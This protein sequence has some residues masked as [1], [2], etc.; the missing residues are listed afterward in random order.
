VQWINQD[1][2]VQSFIHDREGRKMPLEYSTSMPF[3]GNAKRA[4]AVAQS[5]LLASNFVV[6]SAS[7]FE[8]LVKCRGTTS[9]RENPLKGMTEGR[10]TVRNS[11]I[12]VSAVLGGAQWLRNFLRIMPLAMAAFFIS[13]FGILAIFLP[14]MRRWWIFPIP[15]A[16]L[17]PWVVLAP[18]LG[19]SMERR[20]TAAID[21][22]ISN[23]VL[24]GSTD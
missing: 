14:D 4:L 10:F 8:L 3:T 16:V 13:V 17:S 20:T 23:M 9:T 24:L 15:I 18:V 1:T 21:D 6:V 22:L 7:D 2:R 19:R 11:A 5:A 12:D